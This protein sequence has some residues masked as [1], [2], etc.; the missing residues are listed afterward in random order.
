MSLSQHAKLLEALAGLKGKFILSGYRSALYDQATEKHG[1]RRVDIEIDNKSSNAREK[2][3]KT[4][5]LWMNY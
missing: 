4:E 3:M 2:P 1:W 5:C